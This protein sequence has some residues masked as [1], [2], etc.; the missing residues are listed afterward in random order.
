[1]KNFPTVRAAHQA[2]PEAIDLSPAEF[3]ARLRWARVRGHPLYLW[4]DVAPEVWR[5]A[6]RELERVTRSLLL[7]QLGERLTA[8]DQAS[9][10]ALG[11]AAFTSGLGPLLGW[12]IERGMLEAGAPERA[13]LALHLE[14]N[15]ER[16]ERMQRTLRHAVRVLTNAGVTVTVLKGAH[17]SHV[18]FPEPGTRPMADLDLLVAQRDIARAEKALSTAGYTTAPGSALKR[19]YRSD[20]QPPG[21]PTTVRSLAL[22]HR[23]NPYTVDLHA[24]LDI[25]FFGVRTIRFGLP[26]ADQLVAAP[27]AG[28]QV[29]ALPLTLLIAYHAAHAAQ[30]LYNLTLIRLVEL[31]LLLRRTA[32]PQVSWDELTDLLRQARAERF[33]FP[34]FELVERLVPGTVAAALRDQL[35]RAATPS[36]RAVVN[37]LSPATAQRL[38]RSALNEK[39]MWAASPIEYIRRAAHMLLPGGGS[40][41][42]LARIYVDRAFRLLRG[43]VTLRSRDTDHA[44]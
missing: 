17:T 3:Q 22:Q 23:D 42:R 40:F 4:P 5:S 31:A 33:V 6:L 14:H 24:S 34:A 26:S 29:R 2:A 32:E 27:W 41:R 19:P 43:R 30:G 37:G 12:W 39:F 20:W 44:P 7:G 16:A 25:S 35:L 18:Y 1:M 28:A 38:E 9:L 11:V 21:I 15:R 8:G 10:R 13:L 36:L